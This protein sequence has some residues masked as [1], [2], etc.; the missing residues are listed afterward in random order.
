MNII[1]AGRLLLFIL[2]SLSLAVCQVTVLGAGES[3]YVPLNGAISS[4]YVSF[5]DDI[6]IVYSQ[7]T[8][9]SA[10]QVYSA[11]RLDY[12]VSSSTS[13]GADFEEDSGDWTLG[14][15]VMVQV[16]I[17][18]NA[19]RPVFRPPSGCPLVG[20]ALDCETLGK[21]WSG[22]ISTWEQLAIQ[23]S[24]SA[25]LT[26]S[27]SDNASCGGD[28]IINIPSRSSS[29]DMEEVSS[30]LL[31]RCSNAFASAWSQSGWNTD[32]MVPNLQGRVVHYTP[33]QFISDAY[34]TMASGSFA[35]LDNWLAEQ[36]L[37]ISPLDQNLANNSIRSISLCQ[38][39][40]CSVAIDLAF[41]VVTETLNDASDLFVDGNLTQPGRLHG[42]GII[43][44]LPEHG[45]WPFTLF[46]YA[47]FGKEY[48][49]RT[50]N[51]GQGNSGNCNLIQEALRAMSWSIVN[52]KQYS[53]INS[54][55]FYGLPIS[56][57]ARANQYTNMPTCRGQQATVNTYIVAI[58]EPDCYLYYDLVSSCSQGS[59][60]IKFISGS[61][62]DGIAS[63]PNKVDFSVVNLRPT[64]EQM[65]T[66]PGVFVVP[67][68]IGCVVPIYNVPELFDEEPLIFDF[69]LLT[70]IYIG[71]V[72]T[73][74]HPQIAALN[75]SVA[76]LLPNAPIVIVY[77]T[78]ASSTAL[79]YTTAI[80]N[81]NSTFADT[82]GPSEIINFDFATAASA[83]PGGR[84]SYNGIQDRLL[85]TSILQV[86]TVVDSAPYSFT[87]WTMESVQSAA[88]TLAGQMYNAAGN[89]VAAGPTSLRASLAE[90]QDTGRIDHSMAL[91]LPGN[92]SWP[93]VFFNFFLIKSHT[94]TDCA[95]YSA[96]ANFMYYIEV[97]P[98]VTN[99][100]L[101][102][103]M[104]MI[105]QSLNYKRS[106]LRMLASITCSGKPSLVTSTCI[107][108][109]GDICSGHGS[110]SAGTCTCDLG[111]KG[112]TCDTLIVSEDGQ[113]SSSG[114][115]VGVIVGPVVAGVC[116]LFL[117]ILVV[118]IVVA[119]LAASKRRRN[120]EEEYLIDAKELQCGEI[121]GQG[122][123][124]V[125]C[126]ANWRG[127]DVAVKWIGNDIDSI[128][129][130]MFSSIDE[131]A[132]DP[133]SSRNMRKMRKDQA[134][135]LRS[136]SVDKR[137]SE[138]FR[139]ETKV[140]SMLRHRHI[141][142]FMAAV[143]KPRY[144]IVMEHMELG[145]LYE[146]LHNEIM[147]MIPL[148][149]KVLLAFH[150]ASGMNF[151][152]QSGME[153]RD[154]KSLNILLNKKFEAKVSDFGL[155]QFKSQMTKT[156]DGQQQHQNAGTGGMVGSVHWAAPEVLS[157]MGEIDYAKADVYSFA[158]VMWEILTRES[159]YSGMSMA[160]IAVKVIRDDMR[161]RLPDFYEDSSQVS[162]SSGG[163]E[164]G[165]EDDIYNHNSV[166]SSASSSSFMDAGSAMTSSPLTA[167]NNGKRPSPTVQQPNHHDQEETETR[168]R[169]IFESR[170]QNNNSS[171]GNYNVQVSVESDVTRRYIELMRLCWSRDPLT[172]PTFNEVIQVLSSLLTSLENNES[173]SSASHMRNAQGSSSASSKRFNHQPNSDMDSMRSTTSDDPFGQKSM[174]STDGSILTKQL[175]MP[176]VVVADIPH[177]YEIWRD[178]PRCAASV[179][180]QCNKLMAGL[181]SLHQGFESVQLGHGKSVDG[182]KVF[183]FEHPEAALSWCQNVQ[184]ALRDR[185][186]PEELMSK[187][188]RKQEQRP[189]YWGPRLRMGIHRGKTSVVPDMVARKYQYLGPTVECAA[190][191]CHLAAADQV[192]VSHEVVGGLN[193]STRDKGKEVVDVPWVNLMEALTDKKIH[194]GTYEVPLYQLRIE[195]ITP[196][197][198]ELNH[199]N[200]NEDTPR[201]M[202]GRES[203]YGHREQSRHA[204]SNDSYA[205]MK[206]RYDLGTA[207][208]CPWNIDSESAMIGRQVG[209]GPFGAV[210]RGRWQGM[211][212]CVKVASTKNLCMSEDERLDFM[213]D[214]NRIA[215]LN[216]RC[217]VPFIGACLDPPTIF[218]VH[219]WYE[220]SLDGLISSTSKATR[221]SFKN[222]LRIACD[223][224]EALSYLHRPKV[225]IIHKDVNPSNI[226]VCIEDSKTGRLGGK[227][228]DFGF[229][230]L[231]ENNATKTQFEAPCWMAPEVMRGQPA[232][233]ASDVYSLGIIMWQ[234]ITLKKNPFGGMNIMEMIS[235]ILDGGRPT[236]EEAIMGDRSIPKEYHELMQRCW[237]ADPQVRPSAEI[238]FASLTSIINNQE[239]QYGTEDNV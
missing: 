168:E 84:R 50:T 105:S 134:S 222:S 127:T 64:A 46:V 165:H 154:L 211:E 37:N 23:P 195:G 145:S 239:P 176:T 107:N 166:G 61:A 115:S 128:K 97:A 42:G 220:Q 59:N 212:V 91:L 112:Q 18:V 16:P 135:S 119:V 167:Q 9:A 101:S 198:D 108:E 11:G 71:Q 85:P 94:D 232:T 129:N 21:V 103:N 181:A 148:K 173:S 82:F 65:E 121:I 142:M 30:R 92:D 233:Q 189:T 45:Q 95:K 143:N 190:N 38:L 5:R 76:H 132:T 171:I 69:D 218:L 225:S 151:L 36:A 178:S 186:W 100:I 146:L 170:N 215:K 177:A 87:F 4:N 27:D 213:D 33:S 111:Y 144:A 179:F 117:V 60:N 56:Y 230:R 133:H 70:G 158:I 89:V 57:V 73:W 201:D 160:A 55:G 221:I 156:L 214:A 58:G 78:T 217:V 3:N 72:D 28:I 172:R 202:E 122:T 1:T 29:P 191:V 226:I 231:K 150:T 126:R 187:K 32:N 141:V 136:S 110:C 31:A 49:G 196:A 54:A 229:A 39:D 206:S 80:S 237:D 67:M 66:M 236:L 138:T 14:F 51:P 43:S 19:F 234:L 2:S 26:Y 227:L 79:L 159:P 102:S 22:N 116:L 83:S 162:S 149:L 35:F 199:D 197:A 125:V 15:N 157:D 147:P 210:H 228:T 63:M 47:C 120:Q 68:A 185:E 48:Q 77:Q 174:A 7:V 180:K 161:P 209:Q 74:D 163:E 238:I 12:V 98:T 106:L 41:S 183:I 175:D 207:G 130:A 219:A 182:C 81:A 188:M 90:I 152:H 8:A 24:T 34:G 193:S 216:H 104:L 6:S 96:L 137:N 153:H 200:E 88:N 13:P 124:G 10:L 203:K 93:I 208:R 52:N 25:R 223:L 224:A 140:M 62:Q 53:N 123:F 164:N 204:H 205:D 99:A 44:G 20:M 235:F 118:A 139:Q 109:I 114:V 192:L 194:L 169:S 86:E 17:A 40:N 184:S 113:K 75:P 155:T 131:T